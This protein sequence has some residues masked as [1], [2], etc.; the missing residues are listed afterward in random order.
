MYLMSFL[1]QT[2][3]AKKAAIQLQIKKVQRKVIIYIEIMLKHSM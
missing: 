3:K 1:Q 2:H